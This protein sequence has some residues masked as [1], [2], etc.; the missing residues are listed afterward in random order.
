MGGTWARDFRGLRAKDEETHNFWGYASHTIHEDR[1][2]AGGL[3]GWTIS[4]N[5]DFDWADFLN[6][7]QGP[8]DGFGAGLEGGLYG[9]S[10]EKKLAAAIIVQNASRSRRN[11]RRKLTLR[12]FDRRKRSGQKYILIRRPAGRG[13]RNQ[14]RPVIP[15]HRGHGIDSP[16]ARGVFHLTRLPEGAHHRDFQRRRLHRRWEIPPASFAGF[17]SDVTVSVL[18]RP[19]QTSSAAS[20]RRG[21]FRTHLSSDGGRKK[22]RGITIFYRDWHGEQWSTRAG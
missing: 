4:S 13:R 21:L 9:E 5:G 1:G 14:T 15:G 10:S 19:D 8:K 6:R 22:G 17:G 3:R 12:V 18:S 11:N 20:F 2:N 7:Q 16:V